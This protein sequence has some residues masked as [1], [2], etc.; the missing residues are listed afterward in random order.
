MGH[1]DIMATVSSGI[2]VELVHIS[3]FKLNFTKPPP[4]Q[5]A[6]AQPPPTAA[7]PAGDVE[8][9]RIG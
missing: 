1:R 9:A 4:Q 3:Y 2:A 7:E 8:A 6:S 5:K